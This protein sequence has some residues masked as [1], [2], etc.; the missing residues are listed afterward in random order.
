[1]VSFSVMSSVAG[2]PPVR[3]KKSP[4]KTLGAWDRIKT[5]S[6]SW[7]STRGW[8]WRVLQLSRMDASKAE[9]EAPAKKQKAGRRI[10]H[11]YSHHN[12]GIR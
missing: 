9:E 1:M 11:W 8:F 4:E 2:I 12:I 6:G 10:M 7:W 3:Q 5:P